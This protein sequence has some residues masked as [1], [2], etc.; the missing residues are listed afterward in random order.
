MGG[1]FLFLLACGVLIPACGTSDGMGTSA[2]PFPTSTA[3]PP[4]TTMP[5][6]AGS[7]SGTWIGSRPGDGMTLD[8]P[9]CEACAGA[10]PL[11]A[12]D[13]VMD[14]SD[15]SHTLTGNASLTVREAPAECPAGAACVLRVGDVIPA[16][17]TGSV[18]VGARVAMQWTAT[19]GGP[20]PTML[21]LNLV[22]VVAAN[23]MSGTVTSPGGGAS[24]GS[25]AGTW[26]VRLP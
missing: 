5:R 25:G 9:G 7:L 4:A 21:V 19:V 11:T 12:M 1:R 17:V 23:R 15:T 3:A 14:I 18:G 26:S 22:G 13:V 2:A 24:A 6:D 10:S 20:A 16:S 8:V